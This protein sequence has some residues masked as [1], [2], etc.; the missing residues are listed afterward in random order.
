MS[1]ICTGLLM[2]A[3]LALAGSS[4]ASIA[5]AVELPSI[6]QAGDTLCT[7]EADFDDFM[8]HARVRPNSGI[9]TC[10]R[11]ST[12]VRVAIL[13]GQAGRKTMV[14]VIAGPMAYSIGWTNG[15]LP[16]PP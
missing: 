8:A 6:L 3:S 1:R 2:A 5:K 16:L 13:S 4:V 9:E 10:T 14:R 7:S 12:P 15:N 11:M